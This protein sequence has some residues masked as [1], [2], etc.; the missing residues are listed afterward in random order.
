MKVKFNEHKE[1]RQELAKQLAEKLAANLVAE[2][3]NVALLY[4]E[5]FTKKDRLILPS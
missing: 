3:G 1:D 5:N 4:R 2:I